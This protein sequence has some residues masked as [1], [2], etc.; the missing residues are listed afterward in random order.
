MENYNNVFSFFGADSKVGVTMIVT[1]LSEI[2]SPTNK[3]LIINANKRLGTDYIQPDIN[4]GSIDDLRNK[5]DSN[6]LEYQDLEKIL[7]KNDNLHILAGVKEL[8]KCRH[9]KP[10]D[11]DQILKCVHEEYDLILIDSGSEFEYSG[12][13]I[14]SLKSTSNSVL[15]T[16]QQEKTWNELQRII[17]LSE[18]MEIKY[19]YLV[20]NKLQPK[21]SGII[22]VNTI[23]DQTNITE[24][25][26]QIPHSAYS[27]QSE[28]DYKTLSHFDMNYK[29][30][31]KEMAQKI[32]FN[33]SLELPEEK[34]KRGFSLFK[35]K[36]N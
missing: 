36:E 35:R 7:I 21:G 23:R 20:V 29:K 14:G 26:G 28:S 16:T 6:I 31:I 2:L 34:K 9:F 17:A 10:D 1:S 24:T 25:L 19:K 4:I 22:E 33:L 15:V 18:R 12:L 30:G 8:E 27:W 13:A 32:A 11:M 5:L 3:V